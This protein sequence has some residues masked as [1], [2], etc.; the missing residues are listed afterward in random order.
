MCFAKSAPARSSSTNLTSWQVAPVPCVSPISLDELVEPEM[1]GFGAGPKL[2]GLHRY[3][4]NDPE[5]PQWFLTLCLMCGVVS[6]PA[7]N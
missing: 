1:C 7:A 2:D 6:P 5:M 4:F 3:T